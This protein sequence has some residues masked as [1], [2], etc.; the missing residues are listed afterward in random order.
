MPISYTI[1]Y[2]QGV[3][4]EVWRDDVTAADLHRHWRALHTDP[5][6]LA[7]RKT[8]VDVRG[9]R[10]LFTGDEMSD[11]VSSV[12]VPL[13]DGRDWITAILLEQPV[14][15]GVSRQYQIFA[16]R[17]SKDSIFHDYDEALHWLRDS[18]DDDAEERVFGKQ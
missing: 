10:L 2:V 7:I 12:V 9:S 17:Y 1:D 18:G 3:I 8:L 13:L 6:A 14:H 16:E 11:L 5:E 15:F 4:F